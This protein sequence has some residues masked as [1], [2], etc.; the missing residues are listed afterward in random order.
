MPGLQLRRT[1]HHLQESDETLETVWEMSRNQTEQGR[2][3]FF[4]RDGVMYRRWVPP[5]EGE[6]IVVDQIVLPKS[7]RK[8]AL[9]IPHSTPTAGHLGKQKTGGRILRCFYWPTLYRDVADF[10]WSCGTCQRSTQQKVPR[11]PL[12]SLPLILS[13]PFERIAMDI[14]GP[15]PRSQAGN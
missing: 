6:E 9:Q 4:R 3:E 15:L 5:G 7:C 10:C 14:V 13:E 2:C 8:P 12:I 11:A 1:I